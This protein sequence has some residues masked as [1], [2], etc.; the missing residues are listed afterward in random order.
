MTIRIRILFVLFEVSGFCGLIYESIWSHYLKLFLGH[1]AYAQTVVLV[2][3]I[4]GLAL[5]SWLAGHFAAR[6]RRP[7]LVYAGPEFLV[8]IAALLFHRIFVGATSWA[9]ETLLPA[10]CSADHWCWSQWMFA[11]VMILPQSVLLGTTFAL[12]SGGIL[13]L[14]PSLPGRK[15][16]LLYFLN[17]IGAV[18]GVLCSG[19]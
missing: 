19:Y 10:A 15:L 9:Y 12:M 6:L 4:G 3:F 8:G 11:G 18:F 7:L 16:S 2:V 17:S 5:G 13:R 14:D 1:A